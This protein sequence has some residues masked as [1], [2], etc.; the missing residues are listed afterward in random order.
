MKLV[1]RLLSRYQPFRVCMWHTGR[2][3]SSVVADLIQRDGRI[4][5]AGEV[6]ERPS[7]EWAG[8]SGEE[9]RRRCRKAI[10]RQRY[11][12][13]RKPFGFEMKLW[14]YR[15]LQQS[16]LEARR[17]VTGLGFERHIV[18]ERRNYLRQRVSG[19]VAEESGR[20]HRKSG[21]KRAAVKVAIDLDTLTHFIEL[22]EEFYGTIRAALSDHLYLTYEDDIELDPTAAYTKIMRYVDLE[23]DAVTTELRKTTTRSLRNVIEN[24][25]EVADALSGT[26]HAWMLEG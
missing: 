23:P 21:E 13:G 7:I 4:E 12:A 8:L 22:C 11:D 10:D 15:R 1:R 18:L 16:T 19:R 24:Y 17:L 20:Y 3:G 9:A 25:E 14:H 2:C 5:W 26:R 6:L